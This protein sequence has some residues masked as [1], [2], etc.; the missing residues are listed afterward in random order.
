VAFIQPA[1]TL[2]ISAAVGFI[3]LSVIMPM[4]SIT[5]AF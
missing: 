2:G 1:V 5:G 4:Y 3:A